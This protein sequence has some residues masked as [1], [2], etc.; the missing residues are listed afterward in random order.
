MSKALSKI[1]LFGCPFSVP[2]EVPAFAPFAAVFDFVPF[3][4]PFLVEEAEAWCRFDGGDV[5]ESAE[6]VVR[7]GIPK[8]IN[9]I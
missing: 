5:A 6:R 7:F 8:T 9:S 3:D 4:V 2:F 1:C